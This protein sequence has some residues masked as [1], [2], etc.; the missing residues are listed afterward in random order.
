MGRST[1]GSHPDSAVLTQRL[2]SGIWILPT[3]L[4]EKDPGMPQTQPL[5]L[6]DLTWIH[7]PVQQANLLTPSRGER[8]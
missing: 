5:L 7:L 3:D 8:K 1:F 4:W 6:S 2:S